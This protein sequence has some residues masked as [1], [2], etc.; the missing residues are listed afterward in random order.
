MRTLVSPEQLRPTCDDVVIG[1]GSAGCV[2]A[3]RLGRA[4]RRL[5]IIEAGA[6]PACGSR[7]VSC[8]PSARSSSRPA[9][10]IRRAS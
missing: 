9:P 3:H 1:A 8:G 7:R 4:G 5:L 10:S 6:A 2:L